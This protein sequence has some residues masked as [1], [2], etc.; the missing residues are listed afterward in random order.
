MPRLPERKPK[1]Q[2][3]K[4]TPSSPPEQIQQQAQERTLAGLLAYAGLLGTLATAASFVLPDV[5]LFGNFNLNSPADIALGLELLLP[6]C[7]LNVAIM[8]PDYSSWKVPTGEPTLEAQQSMAEA[9]LQWTA[10]QKAAKAAGAAP[11]TNA[12]ST[13][14]SAGGAAASPSGAAASHAS[15]SSSEGTSQRASASTTTAT[16][17]SS[18]PTNQQALPEPVVSP[19]WL[20]SNPDPPLPLPLARCKDALLMAQVRHAGNQQWMCV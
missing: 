17:S 19:P 8:L 10:K 12:S 5:D 3:P 9:L 13:E 16:S 14:P 15:S 6:A 4:S 18:T 2:Q 1:T 7:L 20:I 11:D